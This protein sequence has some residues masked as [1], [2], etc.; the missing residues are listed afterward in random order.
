MGVGVGVGEGEGKKTQALEFE[1][2]GSRKHVYPPHGW[3]L[4]ILRGWGVTEAN[5]LKGK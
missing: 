4:E 3:L 2:C 1:M 5:I